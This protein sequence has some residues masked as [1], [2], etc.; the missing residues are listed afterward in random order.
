M[1]RW[2]R[3]T[4]GYPQLTDEAKVLN[5]ESSFSQNNSF[6]YFSLEIKEPLK[7]IRLNDQTVLYIH[8][9]THQLH[10]CVTSI[11]KRNTCCNHHCRSEYTI[12]LL[13]HLDN[14]LNYSHNDHLLSI[15]FCACDYMILG[16]KVNIYISELNWI[17]DFAGFSGTFQ[18]TAAILANILGIQ[19]RAI[20]RLSLI[21]NKISL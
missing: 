17:L 4:P 20:F 16:T 15:D 7:R 18:D 1:L 3:Q 5:L 8:Q 21:D 13:C 14:F 9:I 19:H 6:F 10:N 12:I 11:L 2:S